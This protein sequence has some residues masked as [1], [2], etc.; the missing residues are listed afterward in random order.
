[1]GAKTSLRKSGE[2]DIFGLE[3]FSSALKNTRIAH[4]AQVSAIG[5]K[6]KSLM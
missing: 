1:M 3:K 6:E 4:G 5:G 2:K